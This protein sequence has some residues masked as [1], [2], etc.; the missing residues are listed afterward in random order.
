MKHSNCKL[1]LFEDSETTESALCDVRFVIL[2]CPY[3]NIES[4]DSSEKH[5]EKPN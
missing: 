3:R 2:F 5:M 1:K 4:F